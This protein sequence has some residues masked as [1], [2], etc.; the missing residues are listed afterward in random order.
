MAKCMLSKL[1]KG[2]YNDD[3]DD[4]DDDDDNEKQ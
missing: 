2:M 1:V 4:D 3:D